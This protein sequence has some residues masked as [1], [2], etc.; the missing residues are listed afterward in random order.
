MMKC[1]NGCLASD[2]SEFIIGQTIQLDGE[3]G[4][5]APTFADFSQMS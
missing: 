5:H 2:A 3:A 1:L 4:I